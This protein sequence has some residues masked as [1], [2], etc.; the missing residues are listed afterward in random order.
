MSNQQ[1]ESFQAFDEILPNINEGMDKQLFV[2]KESMYLNAHKQT[3]KSFNELYQ[4]LRVLIK[5]LLFVCVC[6]TTS[7]L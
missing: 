5:L 1:N 6:L 7:I 4:I 3:I 2:N